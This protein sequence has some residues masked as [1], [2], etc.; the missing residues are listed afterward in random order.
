MQKV[1]Q[2]RLYLEEWVVLRSMKYSSESTVWESWSFL[3]IPWCYFGLDRN[4][5]FPKIH[6]YPIAGWIRRFSD[7]N[8]RLTWGRMYFTLERN[9][10][11]NSNFLLNSTNSRSNLEALVSSNRSLSSC[12]VR[13]ICLLSIFMFCADELS[14]TKKISA[15]CYLI[16]IIWRAHEE[17]WQNIAELIS[18][19]LE[20][21]WFIPI[22][23]FLIEYLA[24]D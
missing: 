18:F 14:K 3:E 1:S 12:E 9:C 24:F 8:L 10:W 4:T 21:L 23:C 17:N 7:Q 20:W 16:A 19:F 11:N 5:T 2:C 13:L 6:P 22:L 15:K